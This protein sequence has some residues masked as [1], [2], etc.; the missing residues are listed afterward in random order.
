M[1][2]DLDKILESIQRRL[3]KLT[4]EQMEI[5]R[6]RHSAKRMLTR[7]PEAEAFLYELIR[8]ERPLLSLK[9]GL[10]GQLNRMGLASML[11]AGP[12]HK[13]SLKEKAAKR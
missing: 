6:L 13:R 8:R 5:E 1:L 11:H 3:W 10:C 7:N 4:Q 2:R 12:R 9:L